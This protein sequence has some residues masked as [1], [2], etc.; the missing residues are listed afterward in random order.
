MDASWG[1]PAVASAPSLCFGVS[2][3][4]QG[5]RIAPPYTDV[6]GFFA[7]IEPFEPG[8]MVGAPFVLG[9]RD[10]RIFVLIY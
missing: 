9:A 10:N 8:D 2:T 6:R 1:H 7:S 5:F 3:L 4:L